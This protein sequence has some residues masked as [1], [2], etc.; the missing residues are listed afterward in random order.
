MPTRTSLQVASAMKQPQP[1]ARLDVGGDAE[2]R[3]GQQVDLVVD[4]QPPVA[5]VEDVEVGELLGLVVAVGEDLVGRQGDRADLLALAGVLGD[6]GLLQVGLVEDLAPPL[7][8]G[9]DAGG[10]H[11]GGALHQRHARQA[12]D[13]LAGAARQD[14]DA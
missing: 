13:R 1:A 14:D 4:D 2:D 7:L 10:Q 6:L 9:G 5:L 11:Q 3:G 12:D 8:D